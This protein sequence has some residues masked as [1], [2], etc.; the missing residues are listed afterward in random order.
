[1]LSC[2]TRIR[3]EF[4]RSRRS[5]R[6]L[7]VTSQHVGERTHGLMLRSD[8]TRPYPTL[9]R[10]Y[11]RAA[12]GRGGLYRRAAHSGS[13]IRTF[14]APWIAWFASVSICLVSAVGVAAPESVRPLIGTPVAKLLDDLRAQGLTFIYNSRLVP[15]HMRV[16]SEP[17]A[18]NGLA[19][20]EEILAKHGLG[21]SRVTPGVFAVV[22]GVKKVERTPEAGA[23]RASN[24]ARIEEIVVQTSRYALHSEYSVEE[25]LL[26]H[27]DI[28]SLPSLGEEP[29]RAVQRLPGVASNGFS[30]IGAVRGGVPNETAVVLDGLR[31]YEPFH[32]KDFMS[33]VSLLDSRVVHGMHVHSGGFPVTHG[34]RMSA[35]VDMKTM[36]PRQSPYYEAGLSLFHANLLAS[37]SFAEGRTRAL[38]LIRRS[39]LSELAQ[40]S[41]N[42]LGKPEYLD[43]FAKLDHR[44]SDSSRL[45][46][47]LLASSDR[48]VALR[49]SARERTEAE[50]RNTYL[51]GT[52][53]HRWD[54]GAQSRLIVSY[55]DLNNER[56]GRIDEPGRRS[57]S[58]QDDRDFHVLG[59]RADHMFGAW[60]LEHRAGFEVRHLWGRYAYR[61][62]VRFDAGFPFADSRP[63]ALQR[64][65]S[66]KPDGFESAAWW[67]ARWQI[68]DRWTLQAGLRVD[69]QT[70]DGSGDGEQIAPRLNVLYAFDDDTRT[71]DVGTILPTS[72]DQ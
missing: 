29:L 47:E 27:N 18:R 37:T 17:T 63:I 61:S 69:T 33:P 36:A 51:W 44:L 5:N 55:T 66:P 70:Y 28:Q 11:P 41:E 71:S 68:D 72:G 23:L 22:P 35:I 40:F 49:N 64:R 30:S 12:V 43:G 3:D 54:S 45:T 14:A 21:V 32:L 20:A 50:Y 31:L 25:T 24:E 1:M 8:K 39:N 10:C 19:L 6:R 4:N 9:N 48:I 38:A 58:I 53:E 34:D 15:P 26:T 62:D 60:G 46:V 57:G 67:G 59:L 42:D 52:F 7:G 56:D 65:A 13:P 2:E 16:E